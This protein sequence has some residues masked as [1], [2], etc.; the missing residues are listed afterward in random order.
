M[1]LIDADK[2]ISDLKAM[3][4]QL[5]VNAILI[6]GM[7]DG[8][9]RQPQVDAVEVVRCKDCRYYNDGS[10]CTCNF[11]IMSGENFCSFGERRI[12]ND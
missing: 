7:I 9:K 11:D 12:G 6:D 10:L 8:L 3:K 4:T 1:R 5:G 2:V